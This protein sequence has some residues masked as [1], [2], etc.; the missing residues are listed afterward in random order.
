MITEFDPS[1]P[2]LWIIVIAFLA[3]VFWD[4]RGSKKGGAKGNYQYKASQVKTQ[5]I[6]KEADKYEVVVKADGK[7]LIVG[8]RDECRAWRK[9]N[10]EPMDKP[11]MRRP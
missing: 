7:V 11:P 8:T 1:N 2:L 5:A 9:E 10:V 4:E 6:D 3:F